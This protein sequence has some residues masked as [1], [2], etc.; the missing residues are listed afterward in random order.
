MAC[1]VTLKRSIDLDVLHSPEHGIKRRRT[2]NACHH[3]PYQPAQF[4]IAPSPHVP[5]HQQR[6]KSPTA[7]EFANCKVSTD[8]LYIAIRNELRRRGT[9]V[10]QRVSPSSSP[11]SSPI[12]SNGCGGESSA[13][14][15][16]EQHSA[17]KTPPPA[18][19]LFLGPKTPPPVETL[20]DKPMFSFKQ[21]Q[22]IC[23]RLLKEQETRLCTEYDKILNAKM[24]EQYDSFV[25]FTYDQIHRRLDDTH[26]S[27]YLS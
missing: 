18:L 13:M 11:S 26:M 17:S 2:S 19:S 8:E 21:V 12:A 5:Q 22:I 1:G 4:G 14:A 27:S 23:D 9:S 3:S 20:R 10:W 24:A 16:D 7:S 6:E 25:K 15:L